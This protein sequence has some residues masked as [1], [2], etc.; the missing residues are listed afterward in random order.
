MAIALRPVLFSFIGSPEAQLTGRPNVRHHARGS[1]T[2]CAW[3]CWAARYKCRAIVCLLG[4]DAHILETQQDCGTSRLLDFLPLDIFNRSDQS[5]KEV[6]A[7]P[8]DFGFKLCVDIKRISGPKFF[9]R[10]DS[11]GSQC[12]RTL[13][14]ETLKRSDARDV[15]DLHHP[16]FFLPN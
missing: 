2:S 1:S 13:R 10:I 7:G 9:D 12:G 16:I 11:Y 5:I 4:R 14:T 15:L 8:R 3:L 6:Q